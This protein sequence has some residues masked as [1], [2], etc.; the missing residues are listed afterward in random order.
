MALGEIPTVRRIW[1]WIAA[2]A[3]AALCSDD[4][5]RSEIRGFGEEASVDRLAQST[6]VDVCVVKEGVCRFVSGVKSLAAHFFMG[7]GEIGRVPRSGY[8]HASEGNLGH[9]EGGLTKGLGFHGGQLEFGRF[10]YK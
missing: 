3:N 10:S 1:T 8:P 4:G 2:E 5:F 9:G 7:G 6:T